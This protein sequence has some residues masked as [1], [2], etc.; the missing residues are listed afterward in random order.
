[1]T[2]QVLRSV[3]LGLTILA[4]LVSGQHDLVKSNCRSFYS[5]HVQRVAEWSVSEVPCVQRGYPIATIATLT[6]TTPHRARM[7]PEPGEVSGG[8]KGDFVYTAPAAGFRPHTTKC[9]P[10]LTSVHSSLARANAR[11]IPRS[12]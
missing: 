4:T 10:R 2:G 6:S 9:R 8:S 11:L 7:V 12:V 3:F 1:M 5:L